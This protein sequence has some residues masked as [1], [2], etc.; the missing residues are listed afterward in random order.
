MKISEKN[1]M[2][3]QVYLD[4]RTAV[5]SATKDTTYRTYKNSMSNFTIR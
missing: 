5:N 1:Q 2:V 3:Y 4:S